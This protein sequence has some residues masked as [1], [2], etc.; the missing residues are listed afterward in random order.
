MR[1]RHQWLDGFNPTHPDNI[2]H[3]LNLGAIL[4]VTEF[5]HPGRPWR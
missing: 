5:C 3:P 4:G 2:D 1:V